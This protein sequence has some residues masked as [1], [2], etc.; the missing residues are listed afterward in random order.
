MQARKQLQV[1]LLQTAL[2][3]S[4][5]CALCLPP[6]HE[7]APPLGPGGVTGFNSI[8]LIHPAQHTSDRPRVGG[9]AA[10]QVGAAAAGLPR[11]VRGGPAGEDTVFALCVTLPFTAFHFLGLVFQLPSLPFALCSHC[12]LLPSADLSPSLHC[13]LLT[14]HCRL[15]GGRGGSRAAA[16]RRPLRE[17]AARGAPPGIGV[18]GDT[19]GDPGRARRADRR[20]GRGRSPRRG[21]TGRRRTGAG[22]GGGQAGRSGGGAGGAARG[23]ACGQA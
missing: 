3:T 2:V 20:V 22:R 4:D 13:L 12:R 11:K 1:A 18:S 5:C 7:M 21:R 15:P 9:G 10:G 19:R 17:G 23:A 16:T 6:R 14:L 8:A